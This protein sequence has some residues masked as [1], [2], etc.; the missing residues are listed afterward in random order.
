MKFDKPF[1][2]FYRQ[3]NKLKEDYNINTNENNVIDYLSSI[4]YYDL[5]NGYKEALSIEQNFNSLK[6]SDIFAFNYIDKSIQH[7]LFKYSVYVENRFKTILAYYVSAYYG[8]DIP[9]YLDENL[10]YTTKSKKA[11]NR[12]KDIPNN[13]YILNSS[14]ISYRD[15]H[16]HIPPWILFKNAT[17]NDCIDLFSG[18]KREIQKD[19]CDMLIDKRVNSKNRINFTIKSLIIVRKF[20][21]IIAHNLKFISYN[22]SEQI[23]LTDLSSLYGGSLIETDDFLN[24]IGRNDIYSMILCIAT[25]LNKK[26]LTNLF[27]FDLSRELG[28]FNLLGTKELLEKYIEK[29]KIPKNILERI[30]RE[31]RK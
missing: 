18:L 15:N 8:V 24:G 26:F 6:L 21:N 12:I 27:Y 19:I 10:Y 2:D 9:N 16:N 7:I 3:L 23:T 31:E 25:L 11:V 28:R 17:F 20:R 29:T 13:E 22:T 30:E 4:S 5:I 1:R 14:T